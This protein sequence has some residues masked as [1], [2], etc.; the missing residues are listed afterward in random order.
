MPRYLG[1]EI[2]ERI[3]ELQQKGWTDW[4]IAKELGLSY[5]TVRYQ[6]PEVKERKKLQ[7][8]YYQNSRR[9]WWP[10]WEEFLS[11]SSLETIPIAILLI[12]SKSKYGLRARQILYRLMREEQYRAR[13]AKI[14]AGKLEKDDIIRKYLVPVL[15]KM[16]K[17]DLVVYNPE[18]GRYALLDGGRKLLEERL[19]N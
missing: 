8:E 7:R 18:N 19:S 1:K 16:R 12:L 13:L 2:K 6:R 15:K 4:R 11:S 3:E 5:A 14:D 9:E 10:E 17:E